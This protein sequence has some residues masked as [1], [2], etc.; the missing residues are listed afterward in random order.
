MF[1]VYIKHVEKETVS[2]KRFIYK[3]EYHYKVISLISRL[4]CTLQN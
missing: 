4:N 1:Y 3:P 2:I